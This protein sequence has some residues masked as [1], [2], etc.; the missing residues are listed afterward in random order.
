MNA[1]PFPRW[2]TEG[3]ILAALVYGVMKLV[4]E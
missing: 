3:V 4:L 1:Y 2:L